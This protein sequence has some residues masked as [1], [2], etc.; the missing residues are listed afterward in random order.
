MT[1]MKKAR[2]VPAGCGDI[3]VNIEILSV[4]LRTNLGDNPIP[5]IKLPPMLSRWSCVY[6]YGGLDR[7]TA[8]FIVTEV[9]RAMTK[10]LIRR[11]RIELRGLLRNF[12]L[13]W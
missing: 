8:E 11:K 3:S 13:V 2:P 10:T 7:Q 5:S 4:Y 12:S 9:F 1:P 6:S